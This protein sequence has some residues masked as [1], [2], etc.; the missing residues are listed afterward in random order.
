MW[1]S[2]AA[3]RRQIRAADRRHRGLRIEHSVDASGDHQVACVSACLRCYAVCA[4]VAD[5]ATLPGGVEQ[6]VERRHQRLI[7]ACAQICGLTAEHLITR[8]AT[9]L[10]M[11]EACA[12]VCEACMLACMARGDMSECVSA[13]RAC[14]T[15]CRRALQDDS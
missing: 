13:C 14:A 10:A 1:C 4:G 2:R 8:S 6:G 3:V 11:C 9:W 15:L 12:A 7:S 5:T